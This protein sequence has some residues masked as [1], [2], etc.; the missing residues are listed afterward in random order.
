[1]NVSDSGRPAERIGG[2][3][4]RA[5]TFSL[6][7]QQPLL[8]RD[9]APDEDKP[10]RAPVVILGYWS[11]RTATAAIRRSSAGRSRSTTRRATIVGVMPEGMQFPTNAD[12]WRPLVPDAGRLAKRDDRGLGVV[13]PARAGR[14]ARDRRST[15]LTGDRG[16]A[17]SSSIPTPTRTSTRR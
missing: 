2:V 11:G 16:P 10:G 7:G 14:D 6:L 13:R 3:A 9:F 8:G 4:S 5:N 1:M 15:E 17:S 12:M